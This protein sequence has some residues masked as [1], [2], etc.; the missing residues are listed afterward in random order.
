[1]N[2]TA[3]TFKQGIPKSKEFLVM[4]CVLLLL[5]VKEGINLPETN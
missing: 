2:S 1:M 4:H 3:K 5:K